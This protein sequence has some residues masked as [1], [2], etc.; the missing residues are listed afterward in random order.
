MGCRLAD[1]NVPRPDD[2]LTGL[3][4]EQCDFLAA[5]AARFDDGFDHESK[6]LALALRV[7]LHDRPQGGSHSLL[8]QLELKQ[9]LNYLDTAAEEE[10]APG[11]QILGPRGWPLGLVGIRLVPGSDA[12][13][14]PMLGSV[15][16]MPTARLGFD[17]WWSKRLL[18]SPD[19]GKQW[20]RQD[21]VLG[22]ANKEGG[23]H[24]EPRPAKWWESLRDGTW[25][26]AATMVGPDGAVPIANLA[27]AVIRQI[28][29]EVLT[30]LEDA[31]LGSR[32]EPTQDGG[33]VE[34]AS[35]SFELPAPGGGEAKTEP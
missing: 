2:R 6:R 16:G 33:G 18:E 25:F 34:L 30:T 35:A 31:G 13:Y 24:V 7:L 20:R 4:A 19:D 3:L 22:A 15:P 26:G 1:M 29:Y 11:K 27:P 21:F 10:P 12:S 5:S 9:Q 17:E 32:P 8:S 28:A 23:A 14:F